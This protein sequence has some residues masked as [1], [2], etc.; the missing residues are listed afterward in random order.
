[1]NHRLEVVLLAA[2]LLFCLSCAGR[3]ENVIPRPA[4]GPDTDIADYV[5]NFNSS[6]EWAH[7]QWYRVGDSYETIG[8][9]VVSVVGNIC[10]SNDGSWAL[11]QHGNLF[12]CI[13]GWRPRS[14]SIGT[15]G[16]RVT[17]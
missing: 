9:F 1:M 15:K 5:T 3:P 6:F 16:S 12:T 14:N 4:P 11:A 17:R 13:G 7:S 2:L 8:F 10:L